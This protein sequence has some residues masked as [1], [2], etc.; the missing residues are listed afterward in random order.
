MP[1]ATTPPLA[2]FTASSTLPPPQTFDILPPLHTLLSRLL[3]GEA[4]N[5]SNL[6]PEATTI[7]SPKD[8]ATAASGIMAKLQKAKTVVKELP[9]VE[10]GIEEQAGVIGELEEE[11]RRL[12][13]VEKGIRSAAREAWR[14]EGDGVGEGAE[15]EVEEEKMEE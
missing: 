2:S 15:G 12:R 7:L 11:V 8:L 14:R 5:I 4:H 9:G 10:M 13:E 3:Q 6:S 1:I